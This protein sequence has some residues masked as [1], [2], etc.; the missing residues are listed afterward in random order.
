MHA[1]GECDL[2]AASSRPQAGCHNWQPL[3]CHPGLLVPL[4]LL[5]VLLAPAAQVDTFGAALTLALVLKAAYG[6]PYT[7]LSPHLKDPAGFKPAGKP[8]DHLP[9]QLP[10]FLRLL[11]CRCLDADHGQR[12]TIAGLSRLLQHLLAHMPREVGFA[13]QHQ[14]L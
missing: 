3:P 4:A 11:L 13:L 1:G 10:S 2:L 14:C 12:T 8:D 5:L 6:Q 9:A 7:P